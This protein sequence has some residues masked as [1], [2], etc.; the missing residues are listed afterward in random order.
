VND[1]ADILS[2]LNPRVRPFT[3]RDTS[4]DWLWSI[5]CRRALPWRQEHGPGEV[6]ARVK[7]DLEHV[8]LIDMGALAKRLGA[9]DTLRLVELIRKHPEQCGKIT[10]LPD[11]DEIYFLPPY[12]REVTLGNMTGT[13]SVYMADKF[14]YHMPLR[15]PESVEPRWYEPQPAFM[16]DAPLP[17]SVIRS[18][19]DYDPPEPTRPELPVHLL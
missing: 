2:L 13:E 18:L 5:R 6:E 10:G 12:R 4:N 19:V 11:G 14:W 1:W 16:V 7:Y 15:A 3:W 9:T 8:D 17:F